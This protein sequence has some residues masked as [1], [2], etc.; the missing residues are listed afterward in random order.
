MLFRWSSRGFEDLRK[1]RLRVGLTLGR[2]TTKQRSRQIADGGCPETHH[3]GTHGDEQVGH[4]TTHLRV[5]NKKVD[6]NDDG[7]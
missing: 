5:E 4:K 1:D 7:R 2:H 3:I 6:R